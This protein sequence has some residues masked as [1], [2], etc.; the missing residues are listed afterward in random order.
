MKS[1]SAFAAMS[2]CFVACSSGPKVVELPNTADP[3][4]EI[5][6]V[7][8]Q[9]KEARSDQM[10]V[11]A[12][13]TF[14][15]A[16]DY[17]DEAKDARANNKSQSTTLHRIAEAK[18]YLGKGHELVAVVNQLMPNVVERRQQ[19]LAANAGGYFQK[20]MTA[21][22]DD[23][24]DLTRD[25]ERGDTTRAEKGRDGLEQRYS[26]IELDSIRRAT[27]GEAYQN[28]NDAL[29]EGAKK[30]TPQTLAAAQKQLGEDDKQ[31]TANRHDA[32][33][34]K[35]CGQDA[36]QVSQH[37]LK[38][39]REA[40]IASQKNPEQIATQ[41]EADQM[42]QQQTQQR[43][44]SKNGVVEDL[45][46]Q[47]QQLEKGARLEKAYEYASRQFNPNEAEV[48]KQGN[49]ILI[50][51]KGMQ[52]PYNQAVITTKSYPLLAKIEDVLKEIQ[53]KVVAI[54][55]HTDSTGTPATNKKLSQARAQAI[56]DY[57]T[58]NGFKPAERLDAIGYGDSKPIAPNTTSNGRAQNRRVDLI[59]KAGED[60]SGSTITQ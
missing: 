20:E 1:W 57:L 49:Q 52:F 16:S 56:A 55:G 53:P 2:L 25:V 6:I 34:L 44:N 21:V 4:R 9:L 42:A 33:I 23:L 17:L 59:L 58:Y 38:L 45:A 8:N 32:D 60:E 37:L 11:L 30:L 41:F 51:L 7:D 54:E 15:N 47:N 48:Y 39:V 46:G 3:N 40:K 19:A 14:K 12:P 50:R 18:A 43:L 28:L 29:H 24:V 13:A 26:K 27:L 36:T 31:V 22:D 10:D 35:K 5:E